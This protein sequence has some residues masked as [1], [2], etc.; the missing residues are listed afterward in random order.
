MNIDGKNIL[1]RQLARND[2]AEIHSKASQYE[3]I[4]KYF[5]TKIRTRQYWEKRFDET[6]LWDESYGMLKII[7]KEDS[8]LIGVI[9]YFRSL[10][11]AEGLE[12]GFNIFGQSKRG[13]GLIAEVVKIFT[14]YLFYTYPIPRIQ[15]NTLVDIS[16][17]KHLAYA[18][19]LN[20][21]YE[22]AMRKA[23]FIRGKYVDLQL[24]SALR[25]EYP[26]LDA[27][28][29]DIHAADQQ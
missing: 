29:E 19:A 6:G 25:E 23:M 16:E 12:I 10:P 21:T 20:F 15:F 4:S 24:F 8:E 1:L 14:A 7:A 18:R 2:I 22:G 17:D 13:R 26:S 27:V 11:Y 28:L 9:W 5:T 3:G